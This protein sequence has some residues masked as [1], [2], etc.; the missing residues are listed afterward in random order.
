MIYGFGWSS[1][2]IRTIEL[3]EPDSEPIQLPDG[4]TPEVIT[5]AEP[6]PA[7]VPA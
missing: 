5:P 4:D 1:P 3:P 6:V 7:G 2:P